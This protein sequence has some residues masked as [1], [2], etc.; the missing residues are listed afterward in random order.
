MGSLGGGLTAFPDAR[1]DD[2]LLEVGVVSAQG[3]AQWAR[4]T[5]MIAIGHASRSRFVQTTRGT[6]VRVR[7]DRAVPYEL[8]GGARG[9][10]RSLR[11]GVESGAALVCVPESAGAL[12]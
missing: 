6:D 2:G 8:D 12:A 10:T 4:V 11:V 3:V 5:S 7:F 9:A 1:P